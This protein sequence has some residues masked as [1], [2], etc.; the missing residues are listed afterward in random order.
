ML[1]RDPISI[2]RDAEMWLAEKQ[3]T[4]VK[5]QQAKRELDNED[6]LDVLVDN[7]NGEY[8]FYN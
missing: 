7:P 2:R 5:L 8:W 6:I 4:E 1:K 3:L